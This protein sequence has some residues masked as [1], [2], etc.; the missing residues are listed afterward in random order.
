MTD[1]RRLATITEKSGEPATT[2]IVLSAD[3]L[4]QFRI[5]TTAAKRDY[6]SDRR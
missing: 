6:S 2:A 5:D 4:E 1:H 3:E